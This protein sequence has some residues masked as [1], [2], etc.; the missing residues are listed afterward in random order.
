MSESSVRRLQPGDEVHVEPF[1]VIG[2]G[3]HTTWL[4][5]TLQRDESGYILTGSG[6]IRD[7]VGVRRVAGGPGS[8]QACQASSPR[9][10]CGR[11]LHEAWRRPLRTAP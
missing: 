5:K 8:K 1:V 11:A 2:A 7:F 4:E 9:A 10:T 3:P 6:V